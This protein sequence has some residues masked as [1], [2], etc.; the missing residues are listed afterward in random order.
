MRVVQRDKGGV[1]T[2][3][4]DIVPQDPFHPVILGPHFQITPSGLL[5]TGTP[6][7]EVCQELWEALRTLE[8]SIAFAIG[9][10]MLLF[11]KQFGEEASQIIDAAGISESTAEVYRWTAENVAPERRRMDVLSY[12][13]HQLV[14]K[15]PPREQTKWL[16]Q[17]AAGNGTGKAWSASRLQAAIKAGS[18]VEARAW[19]LIV[20]CESETKRNKLQARLETE[21]YACK[22]TEKRGEK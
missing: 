9:D 7:F 5:V 8:K 12:K 1:V 22:A 21:G 13:H 20:R 16:S 19:F 15:M 10:A 6:S 14:G 3:A 4:V 18:D 11:R 2:Q 17:A